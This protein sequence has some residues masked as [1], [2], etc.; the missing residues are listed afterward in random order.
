MAT[1]TRAEAETRVRDLN[2]WTLEEKA[3]RKQFVFRGFPDAVAFVSRLVPHAESSDHH[4]DVLINY[5]RVTLTYSTHSEG[6]L[7]AKDFD[8]AKMADRVAAEEAV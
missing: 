8:G 2:G 5:K 3:I 6:G 1:L 7:T 4:P